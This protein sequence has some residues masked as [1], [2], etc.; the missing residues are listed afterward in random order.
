VLLGQAQTW[1]RVAYMGDRTVTELSSAP[2]EPGLERLVGVRAGSG[3]RGALDEALPHRRDDGSLL[4]LLLDEIPVATLISGSALARSGL[5]LHKR[6]GHHMPPVD[7][8]AG[9][10][11]GGE[12]ARTSAEGTFGLYG[13]GP[14]AP[15]LDAGDDPLAWHSAPS[16]PPGSMR[17][18]RRLDLVAPVAP[19][20]PVEVDGHFRDMFVDPD[21]T[22]AVVHEYDV[23]ARVDPLTGVILSATATPRVLPGPQ[24]PLAAD[25]AAE[26]VGLGLRQVRRVVRETFTGITTCTHLNDQLRAVGDLGGLLERLP[27]D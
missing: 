21:G 14:T 18:R 8:C 16:L 6:P 11:E 24:C 19:G 13:Q 17:R 23:A 5:Q 1:A 7:I 3:F 4:V 12:M 15:P 22:E 26:L 25:S 20:A 9:W 10:A 2:D 27:L